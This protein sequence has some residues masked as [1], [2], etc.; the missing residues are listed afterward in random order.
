MER[1]A[2]LGVWIRLQSFYSAS[3]FSSGA[4]FWT[5]DPSDRFISKSEDK[6]RDAFQTA[7]FYVLF[8]YGYSPKQG[9]SFGKQMCLGSQKVLFL[10]GH[11]LVRCVQLAIHSIDYTVFTFCIVTRSLKYATFIMLILYTNGKQH[12][13]IYGSVLHTYLITV[14]V[15]VKPTLS[16]TL[17]ES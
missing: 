10:L 5:D 14:L 4:F 12:E 1:Q 11:K 17:L 13:N 8:D 9:N 16:T 6:S 2:L 3:Y 7:A 15:I